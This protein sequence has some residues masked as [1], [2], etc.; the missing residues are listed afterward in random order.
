MVSSKYRSKIANR[1]IVIVSST[2]RSTNCMQTNTF[3]IHNYRTIGTINGT[4]IKEGSGKR[5]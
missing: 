2:N 4:L 5:V 3:K 1:R